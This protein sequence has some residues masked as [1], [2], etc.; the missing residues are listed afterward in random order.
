MTDLYIPIDSK[1]IKT[2][3]DAIAVLSLIQISVWNEPESELYKSVE[4]LLESIN[5][6]EL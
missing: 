1:K 2:L 3:D 4:H 6:E 5:G